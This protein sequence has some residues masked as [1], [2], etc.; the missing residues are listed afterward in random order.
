MDLVI[1]ALL[2]GFITDSDGTLLDERQHLGEVSLEPGTLQRLRPG[3]LISWSDPP[4]IGTEANEFQKAIIREVAS[5]AGIPPF[6]L[7]GNMGEVNFSSARVALIAFRRRI[8]QWQESML[9]H[10]FLRPVYRRWLSVEILSG[11]IADVAL[12]EATLK[13]KWISPKGVWVDPLKDVQAESLG[14]GLPNFQG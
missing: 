14:Q 8:E 2:T 11:R 4:E 7:D 5:G 1:G 10:Q 6:L 3:E 13:H 12:N 9:A